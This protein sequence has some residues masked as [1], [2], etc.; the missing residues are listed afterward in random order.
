MPKLLTARH[1]PMVS[2][3]SAA[4]SKTSFINSP[5]FLMSAV[6]RAW[7]YSRMRRFWLSGGSWPSLPF[8]TYHSVQGMP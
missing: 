6:A 1:T 2:K 3:A 8:D 4:R 7:S 5:R